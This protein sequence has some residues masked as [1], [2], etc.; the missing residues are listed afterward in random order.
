MKRSFAGKKIPGKVNGRDAFAPH[1][2]ENSEQFRIA[3]ITGSAM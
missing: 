3:D 2:N 1:P